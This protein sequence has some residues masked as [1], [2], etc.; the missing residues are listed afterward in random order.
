M[1]T[2]PLY[3]KAVEENERS[4]QKYISKNKS[5]LQLKTDGVN[6]AIYTIPVVVHVMHTG[7]AVGSIYNPTDVQIQGAINYLNQVYN[8]SYPGTQGI[9][10][11]QIQFALATRDPNCN[12]TAGIERIDA[13]SI[14]GYTAN[15]VSTDPGTEPGVDEYF[16]KSPSVWNPSQYYNIWVVNKINGQDGTSGTFTAGYAYF[17]G[18]PSPYD[19]A[20]MLATQMVSGQKTLPHEIGHAFAL[21]HPFQGSP[22]RNT[23]P[24]N[25]DCNVDGDQ[26]CDTDP[27]TYNQLAGVF[28]FTCRTG[29]NS[30]TGTPYSINTENNYMGYTTCY[31]LF[32]AG[33]KARLLAAAASPER[34][35]LSTSLA[36]N[37]SYPITPYTPPVAASCTPTTGATGLS[38][39]YAGILNIAI[40]N[41]NLG[42]SITMYDN[43]YV[44]GSA[45][46]LN[47]VQLVRGNTYSF[48][49][50][51]LGQNIEQLRAWIDYNNDGVF[52]NATEQIHITNSI[53]TAS[54]TTSGNFTVPATA[55]LNT[56]LR[57][58]VIDDLAVGYPGTSAISG[59]C[60][61][62]VYGQAEDY[63]IYLTNGVLP[64]TL[65]SFTG[66]LKTNNIA[67]AWRTEQENN[68]RNFEIE[69]STNGI[70]FRKI[71]LVTA[72]GQNASSNQY[73][74]NDIQLSENNY[75]RLRMNDLDGTHKL[76]DIV[77]VRIKDA[78]QRVWIVNNPFS[79]HLNLRFGK[80]GSKAV[81]QLINPLGVTVAEK[82]IA[83]PSG[84]V[85][86]NLP[87]TLSKGHY[88]L[89]VLVDGETF[90][91]K[92]IKQ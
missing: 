44:N 29:N 18:A 20:I 7:G 64:V 22:D 73:S 91:I 2:D 86:W 4:I 59:G 30:C 57:M 88:I 43:G 76:S 54:G 34:V 32:T 89:K 87:A 41:R 71:G 11:I 78:K 56:V 55:P 48:T 13:S 90:T 15:G 25:T 8:G 14:A 10:D 79:N 37:P 40:N 63:P 12:V 16:V 45:S 28:D 72:V 6:T 46:C 83:S 38:G 53:P 26:V 35:S 31:T 33:Q 81:V 61:N 67:L 3:R 23:C 70:D 77:Q 69:K 68:L 17:P 80:T 47:L 9:G 85:R 58:R 49:A 39:G 50:N 60:F 51:V 75:Y 66:E 62:P 24:V 84:E 21:Y 1:Q 27:V 52:S 5:S 19:G 74:F 92:T 36:L 42:S 82:I 65:V